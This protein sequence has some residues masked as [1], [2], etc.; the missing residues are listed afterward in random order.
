LTGG[1]GTDTLVVVAG[2]NIKT[3]ATGSSIITKVEALQVLMD[4]ASSTVDFDKLPDVTGVTVRNIGNNGTSGATKA[5]V[6]FTLSNLTAAQGTAITVLHSTTGNGDVT[7]TTVNANL[8]T[9]GTVGVTIKDGVNTDNKFGLTINAGSSTN[10][11]ITDS[12]TESNMVE[13]ASGLTGTVTVKGGTAGKFI[14]F[15]VDTAAVAGATTGL[16]QANIGQGTDGTGV[17]DVSLVTTQVKFASAVFD[18]SGEASDVTARFSTNAASAQGAQKVTMGTG[19]DFVIFDNL[20]DTTA[21]LNISDSVDGGTGDDTLVIDGNLTSAGKIALSASEWTNVKNFE[22]IHLVGAGTGSSYELTLTDALIAANNKAGMLAIVNDNGQ[23]D[24]ALGNESAVVIDGMSLTANSKFSYDGEE[25]TTRTTDRIILKDAGVNGSHII[26]GG[27]ADLL[28][29]T[30][31]AN[32]DVLEI[33]NNAVATLGDLAN[34]KNIGKI[35]FNNDQAVA[36][37]L[38]LQLDANIVNAFVDSLH[39]ASITEREVLNVVA[40]E[41]LAL[42]GFTSVAAAAIDLD[43]RSIGDTSVLTFTGDTAIAGADTLRFTASMSAGAH[44]VNAGLGID[45]LTITGGAATTTLTTTASAVLDAAANLVFTSTLPGV[46]AVTWNATNWENIDATGFLG[47]LAFTASA[48]T[49]SIVAGEGAD[50]IVG[51]AAVTTLGGAGGNDTLTGGNATGT[52]NGGEGNDT[53]SGV[54]IQANGD[55][56][57]DTIGGT[58][59][60]AVMNGGD[61]SD[62]I[63]GGA[64]TQ[65]LNGGAGADTIVSGAFVNTINGGDDVDAITLSAGTAQTVI[66]GNTAAS[67]DNIT[68]FTVAGEDKIQLSKALFA[69]VTSVAGAGFSVGTEFL[70][71][72]GGVATTAAQRIIYNSTTGA[73]TYDADGNGAGAAV[74]IATLVGA[75][76]LVATDFTIVA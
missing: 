13:V 57:N 62:T 59:V 61:G 8:K 40:N 18:A 31:A 32:A 17:R 50:T 23:Q 2:G 49:T 63:T 38:T 44:T 66:V 27:S 70:S 37:K 24:A 1:D 55:A 33:R 19:N 15:D 12:D 20:N 21:G 51:G 46:T 64:A 72:A 53:I 42:A 29:T 22:T 28:S 54:Y 4:G 48:N 39:T 47:T 7:Q 9:A 43:A 35:A 41:G 76:A 58:T 14:N 30:F 10:L 25:H 60:S 6:A 74:L 71:V 36:Q 67:A 68:T 5:D 11:T 56:G 3:G 69:A 52:V 45:L 73:V 34:I 26:D 65:T 75:P 16:K